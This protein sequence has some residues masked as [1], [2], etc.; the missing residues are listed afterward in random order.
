MNSVV[1]T[2]K[3]IFHTSFIIIDGNI[4]AETPQ[5]FMLSIIFNISIIAPNVEDKPLSCYL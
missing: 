3:K 5:R 4:F 2:V 1:M